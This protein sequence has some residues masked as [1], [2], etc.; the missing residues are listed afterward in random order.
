MKVSTSL[1]KWPPL[2]NGHLLAQ[3]SQGYTQQNDEG[4]LYLSRAA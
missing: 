4:M 1:Q 3:R 2:E